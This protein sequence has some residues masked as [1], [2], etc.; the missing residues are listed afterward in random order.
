LTYKKFLE[1]STYH[2][3][4]DLHNLAR[5][6]KD[7]TYNNEV[8]QNEYFNSITETKDGYIVDFTFNGDKYYIITKDKITD[9][10]GIEKSVDEAY[11]NM[12]MLYNMIQTYLYSF[13]I[14]Q[15]DEAI[16][17]QV[18][19]NDLM[20]LVKKS[21]QTQ[22]VDTNDFITDWVNENST[23][24]KKTEKTVTL[25][26]LIQDEDIFD[27]YLKHKE[28]IDKFLV[29]DGFFTKNQGVRGLYE[30]VIDGT[31]QAIL[32]CLSEMKK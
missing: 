16:E 7:F 3:M 1:K 23:P 12:D 15:I 14:N 29:K 4:N 18:L 31:K 24:P 21:S 26:G 28:D 22:N 8:S 17:F 11:Y 5:E 32:L 13:N 19:K 20:E 30:Y 6:I 2:S 9:R 25:E 10:D 27:F